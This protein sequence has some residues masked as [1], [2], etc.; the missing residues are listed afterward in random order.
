MSASVRF[1]HIKTEPDRSYAYDYGIYTLYSAFQPIIEP[2][3]DDLVLAGYQGQIRVLRDDQPYATADFLNGVTPQDKA[4]VDALMA[5]LHISNARIFSQD[6]GTIHVTRNP[7]L[8]D[9]VEEMRA[10]AARQREFCVGS[11]IAPKRLVCELRLRDSDD[12]DQLTQFVGQ[13]RRAGFQIGLDG[14]TGEEGDLERLRMLSPSFVR[15]DP[16][17]VAELGR[18][19]AGMALL[20]VIIEQFAQQKITTVFTCVED[21][22]AVERLVRIG[23]KRLQGHGLARPERAPATFY[24]RF[25]VKHGQA[26]GRQDLAAKAAP[27]AD[28]ERQ[29]SYAI[30]SIGNMAGGSAHPAARRAATVFGRR[31]AN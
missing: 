17:S 6:E 26:S 29:G 24:D 9:S 20:K 14:Y 13:M 4:S 19:N 11:D 31:G 8:F 2:Q 23:A 18:T 30:S 3:A 25:L 16:A 28:V 15:F 7:R 12:M 27:A 22:D 1:D 10:D 21:E 5:A